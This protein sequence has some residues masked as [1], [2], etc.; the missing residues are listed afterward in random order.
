M[1]S[2][3]RGFSLIELLFVFAITS[4]IVALSLPAIAGARLAQRESACTRQ[5]GDALKLVTIFSAANRELP[6][7]FPYTEEASRNQAFPMAHIQGCRPSES[8]SIVYFGQGRLWVRAIELFERRSLATLTCPSLGTGSDESGLVCV[9]PSCG[10]ACGIE[11]SESTYCLTNATLAPPA[12]WRSGAS[13]S[14]GQLRTQPLDG[15]TFPSSKAILFETIR[16]HRSLVAEATITSRDA[17]APVAFGDGHAALVDFRS[18]NAG[19]A[20]R[21]DPDPRGGFNKTALGL[22]GS[23]F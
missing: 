19:V 11:V 10:V 20:N 2:G 21:F 5:I 23:D 1:I 15:I 18:A 3:A 6:P 16:V 12:F 4:L 7:T 17:I 13:Q 8:M 9:P 14:T 22:A